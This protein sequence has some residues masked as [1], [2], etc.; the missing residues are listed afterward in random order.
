[1]ILRAFEGGLDGIL[2]GMI[3]AEAGAQDLVH[4]FEIRLD[5][6]SFAARNTP[7]D[8]PSG[9]EVI[10]AESAEGYDWDVGRDRGHGNVRI[11]FGAFVDDQ[12]VV[13]LVGE[14]DQ[15]VLTR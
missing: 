11:I 6:G 8:A 12:F 9:G 7:S 10:F 5:H 2:L 15:V 14:D 4:A 13:D 3:G 1:M